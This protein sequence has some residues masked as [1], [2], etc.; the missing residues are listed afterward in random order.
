VSLVAKKAGILALMS[1]ELV[2]DAGGQ[3]ADEYAK[4]FG[5]AQGD[6][7]GQVLGAGRRSPTYGGNVGL[8]SALRRPRRTSAHRLGLVVLRRR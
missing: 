4:T 1:N 2:E 8:T 3:R 7:G 5:E 6:L